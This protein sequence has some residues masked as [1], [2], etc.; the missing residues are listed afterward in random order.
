V[1]HYRGFYDLGQPSALRSVASLDALHASLGQTGNF[2]DI[3]L[4]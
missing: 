3:L 1:A 2:T 4:L